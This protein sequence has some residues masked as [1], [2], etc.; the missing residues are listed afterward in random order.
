MRK[1]C[2]LKCGISRVNSVVLPAPLHP[3]RPMIFITARSPPAATR[4][5]NR[6]L[7]HCEE[8]LV[9]RSSKSEGGSDEAIQTVAARAFLDCLAAL[10]MT[11]E[12][13]FRFL[14]HMLI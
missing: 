6:R 12:A 4:G 3:A 8:R 1:P 5:W 7:R 14:R 13:A 11:G 2:A 9:R 10:A